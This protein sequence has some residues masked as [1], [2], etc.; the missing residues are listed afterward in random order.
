VNTLPSSALLIAWICTSSEGLIATFSEV[1]EESERHAETVAGFFSESKATIIGTPFERRVAMRFLDDDW[2]EKPNKNGNL[3]GS[4]STRDP[5]VSAAIAWARS[6]REEPT[7][8]LVICD[9][10]GM[11]GLHEESLKSVWCELTAASPRIIVVAVNSSQLAELTGLVGQKF[12]ILI[13]ANDPSA[14]RRVQQVCRDHREWTRIGLWGGAAGGLEMSIGATLHTL[15]IPLR[16]AA[17]CSAQAA[18]LT[19]ASARLSQ[20][21]RVAWVALIAAGLKAFSPGGSRIRPMVAISVQGTLYAAI[22]QLL[23]WSKLSAFLGGAA[24]GTWA[25]LQGFLLQYL[26]LGDSLLVAYAKATEWLTE[27]SG[28][29]APELSLV[30]TAWVLLHAGAASATAFMASL[31]PARRDLFK[32]ASR[33]A[34]GRRPR[35][36]CKNPSD[37]ISWRELARW[38]F[39]TP[40]VVVAFVLGATGNS[41][42]SIMILMLRFLATG[43][44]LLAVVSSITPRKLAAFLRTRGLWGPATAC[45]QSQN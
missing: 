1:L 40:M 14:I 10:A 34:R 43:A 37:G 17:L 21:L 26:L 39:W 24:I 38:Q 11:R 32:A 36:D 2:R 27:K 28:F 23:G 12:D 22:G 16:G 33:G 7:R 45:R 4:T 18:I 6:L 13:G 5:M 35:A 30:I 25:A 41:W 9:L 31:Q 19:M 42:E 44:V 8:D 3:D 15:R 20:P 29:N